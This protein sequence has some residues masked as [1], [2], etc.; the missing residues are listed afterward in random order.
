MIQ[1]SYSALT[2]IGGVCVHYPHTNLAMEVLLLSAAAGLVQYPGLLVCDSNSCQDIILKSPFAVPDFRDL[3]P[4]PITLSI[5][6]H[7]LLSLHHHLLS[8]YLY[9]KLQRVLL[10]CV[11]QKIKV[12]M[13]LLYH[14]R[15]LRV[16]NLTRRRIHIIL[17]CMFCEVDPKTNA[18]IFL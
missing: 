2:P 10:R 14:D 4:D 6:S 16:D 9:V 1:Q 3:R 11:G 17:P 8:T 13:W 15:L 7:C 12:H 18:H 5:I